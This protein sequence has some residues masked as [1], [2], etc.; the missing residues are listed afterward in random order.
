[1]A[2]ADAVLTALQYQIS[3]FANHLKATYSTS[4]DDIA[5][6]S[7]YHI[8]PFDETAIESFAPT[9]GKSNYSLIVTRFDV[10]PRSDYPVGFL[11]QI[12][13]ADIIVAR[14]SLRTKDRTNDR[15]LIQ[16]GGTDDA[17]NDVT[18]I[19]RIC[20]DMQ[21]WFRSYSQ[22]GRLTDST[23]AENAFKCDITAISTLAKTGD[24]YYKVCSFECYTQETV[25]IS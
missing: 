6:N 21:K 1:M 2:R 12:Y 9:L 15:N 10:E 14:K 7:S 4:A 11:N 5:L 3:K 23:T 17:G 22:G 19:E 13:K 20:N 8:E 16:F 24:F 25:T 18:S